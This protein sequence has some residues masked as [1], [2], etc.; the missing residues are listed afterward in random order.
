MIPLQN[1]A[2]SG[3]LE[4]NLPGDYAV[5]DVGLAATIDE[6]LPLLLC[7]LAVAASLPHEVLRLM[8]LFFDFF[9]HNKLE[10]K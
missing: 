4:A 6:L 10:L 2:S 5:V 3:G 9:G 1:I 7:G 8:L